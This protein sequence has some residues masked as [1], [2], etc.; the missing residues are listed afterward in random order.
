[1]SL[2][3]KEQCLAQEMI[4]LKS[5]VKAEMQRRKGNGSLV[6]YAGTDYDYTV[7]P[8]AGGQMLTEHVNKIVVPMNAI[9]ASGM[10][11]QAVGD[12]AMAMDV[13]DAKL[14]V[15]VAEPAQQ[16]GTSSCSG[17]C[18]GLCVSNCYSSCGGS[19]SVGCGECDTTCSGYCRD[20]CNGGCSGG[21]EGC[22]GT[23]ARTCS[24]NC[25]DACT[26]TCKDKCGGR[27][28]NTCS[29]NCFDS[30]TNTCKNKCVEN[31]GTQCQQL[32]ANSGSH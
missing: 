16:N 6:A 19:C 23:C 32:C 2:S 31:C 21:C 13:I 22:G 11:E 24:V 8:A 28:A 30:C 15:Y 20:S 26:N 1:M 27:C 14:T 25:F 29:V 9:T 4:D 7:D 12:Q 10:T 5:R 17:A 18:S 3:A